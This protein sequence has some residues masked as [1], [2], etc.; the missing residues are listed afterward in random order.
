MIPASRRVGTPAVILEATPAVILEAKLPKPIPA[1]ATLA[2]PARANTLRPT[3]IRAIPAI[4][5]MR[6]IRLPAEIRTGCLEMPAMRI[7]GISFGLRLARW[8]LDWQ[9]RMTPD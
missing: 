4:A 6:R 1:P 2:N 5:T 8:K 3:P 9:R 7:A